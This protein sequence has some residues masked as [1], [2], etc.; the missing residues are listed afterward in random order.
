MK[1]QKEKPE[2][3]KGKTNEKKFTRIQTR[4]RESPHD[5]GDETSFHRVSRT[6]HSGTSI[7]LYPLENL[8]CKCLKYFE[9]YKE[10]LR[11]QEVYF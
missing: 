11:R 4:K 8:E 6:M 10:T 7:Y 2:V 3:M 1:S 5:Y 9:V